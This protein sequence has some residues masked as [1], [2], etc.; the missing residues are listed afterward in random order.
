MAWPSTPLTTYVANFTPAIKALDLNSFQSGINGIVN[1]TYKLQAVTTTAGTPGSAVAPIAGTLQAAA[2]VADA[3]TPNTSLPQG[4]LT[5]GLVPIGWA[6][7]QANGILRLGINVS[8][9]P[10]HVGTGVYRV[11]FNVA[12]AGITDGIALA[13]SYNL[14]DAR[15]VAANYVAVGGK[16]SA[17]VVIRDAAT[18]TV[19]DTMF[20]VVLYAE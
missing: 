12:S 18:G 16:A 19:Q 2:A 7:V 1:G 4:T 14:T 8:A 6:L 20:Q 17:D 11:I 10:T 13:V 15:V 3:V 5:R 9:A